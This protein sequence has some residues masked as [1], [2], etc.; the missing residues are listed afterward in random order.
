MTRDSGYYCNSSIHYA[1]LREGHVG[2]ASAQRG[3]VVQDELLAKRDSVVESDLGYVWPPAVDDEVA[4]A[5]AEVGLVVQAPAI[6]QHLNAG[7]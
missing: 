3:V 2:R 5:L 1:H 7:F 6:G 4:E